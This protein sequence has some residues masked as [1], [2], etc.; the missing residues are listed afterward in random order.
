[1][2]S[3]RMLRV[4]GGPAR[5]VSSV[6]SCRGIYVVASVSHRSWSA[7]SITQRLGMP[8]PHESHHL[9]TV[10]K[11][12]ALTAVSYVLSSCARSPRFRTTLQH[13]AYEQIAARSVPG[14]DRASRPARRCAPASP[15][16]V[17]QVR[18]RLRNPPV[19]EC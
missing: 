11:I 2:T 6:M 9:L 16:L 12:Y 3:R 10:V 8:P 13:S 5:R 1:M 17:S 18:F 15:D 19:L 4:G 14:F 7:S